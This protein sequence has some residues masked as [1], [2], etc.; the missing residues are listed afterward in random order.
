MVRER[1][2]TLAVAF[3][4]LSSM[5]TVFGETSTEYYKDGDGSSEQTISLDGENIDSSVSVK[6]PATEVIDAKIGLKGV[7]NGD[8]DYPEG[9]SV[10]VKN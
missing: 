7:S 9:I 10:E 3:L 6:F 1:I 4:L 5:A 2:L 8:G